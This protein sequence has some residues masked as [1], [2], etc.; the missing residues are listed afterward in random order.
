MGALKSNRLTKIENEKTE[1]ILNNL[2]LFENKQLKRAAILSFGI[3]IRKYFT[4]A[5]VKIGRCGRRDDDLK[6]QEIVEGNAFLL[7]DLTIEILEKKFFTFPISYEGLQRVEGSEYPFE[8]IKEI[9]LNAIV[10]RN[11]VGTPIQVSVYDD[12]F[13]VWNEGTLP[14][15]LT[16]EDLKKKHPSRPRNPLLADIFFKGG[17]IEAWGRGTLKIINE[18]K[19][20]GLFE[21]EI[22]LVGG[23]ISVTIFKDI[24]NHKYL[25]SIGLNT[26]QIK[27]V[28]YLKEHKTI[29]NTK[30]QEL[31]NVSKATSTRDLSELVEKYKLL[32]KAGETSVGT[33]YFLKG[34]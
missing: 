12:K 13:M 16:I 18:C 11:Y 14:E 1:D 19:E 24:Y 30:Y 21:P 28:I 10:H 31:N 29:T 22:E 7:A 15:G 23:G 27:S 8:A 3:D 20:F 34:S 5:Y 4:N 9:L 25:E 26:R 33:T 32:Q 2:R 6:F 17:L